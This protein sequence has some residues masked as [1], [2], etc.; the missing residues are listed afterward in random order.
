[1]LHEA[2]FATQDI[3]R[4]TDQRSADSL[5]HYINSAST[6]KTVGAADV[7]EDL[8][9]PQYE[10]NMELHNSD[11]VATQAASSSVPAA[12][13]SVSSVQNFSFDL[14]SL[15]MALL[16]GATLQ[17]CTINFNINVSK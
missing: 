17:G 15:P 13:S 8:V 3:C 14:N 4:F 11:L 5:K 2:G 6:R 12:S 9:N 1:M 16:G 7:L 10:N